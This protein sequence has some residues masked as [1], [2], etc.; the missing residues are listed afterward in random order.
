MKRYQVYLNQH[1]VSILDE[2]GKSIDISRSKLIQLVVDG[3]AL[4]AAKIFAATKTPPAN[5][6]I[7]DSLVGSIKIKGKKK[8]NYAQNIDEIYLTD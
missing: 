5:T 7:L 8:T 3:I 1:S 6:Y 4:N 2:L